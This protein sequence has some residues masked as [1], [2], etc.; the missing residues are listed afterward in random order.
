M[1]SICKPIRLPS[2]VFET[3]HHLPDPMVAS[4]GHFLPFDEVFGQP[5]SEKYRPSLHSKKKKTTFTALLQHAKNAN[6]LLQ[7]DECGKWRLVYSVSKLSATQRNQLMSGMS[8][9]CGANLQD[10]EIPD[11]LPT[12]FVKDL[13]CSQLTEKLYYSVGHEI[14]CYY[15]GT[16]EPEQVTEDDYYPLCSECSKSKE[17]VKKYGK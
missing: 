3:I 8:F 2:E 16:D 7:C 5:T 11:D 10:L 13:S 1:C 12:V 15:C 6:L 17:R 9:S 4:D 14:V